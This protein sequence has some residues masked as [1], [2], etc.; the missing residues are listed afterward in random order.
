[1]G[2]KAGAPP[3]GGAKSKEEVTLISQPDRGGA[4]SGPSHPT[5][6]GATLR[7]IFAPQARMGDTQ[8][9]ERRRWG[10]SHEECESHP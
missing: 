9:A 3:P 10:V 2:A 5:V 6:P 7:G 8:D 1:M 4:P